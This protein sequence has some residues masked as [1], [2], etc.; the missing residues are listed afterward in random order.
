MEQNSLGE[1]HSFEWE[2]E[3]V[4]GQEVQIISNTDAATMVV[5]GG[6]LF[7]ESHNGE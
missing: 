1:T 4:A 7:V 2:E 6:G 3:Y 5:I